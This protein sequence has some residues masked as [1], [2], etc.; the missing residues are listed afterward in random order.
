MYIYTTVA[1][2]KQIEINHDDGE[3]NYFLKMNESKTFS[4][5]KIDC[6]ANDEIVW[7]VSATSYKNGYNGT[8][9]GYDGDMSNPN[10]LGTGDSVTYTAPPL[11]EVHPGDQIA[12]RASLKSDPNVFDVIIIQILE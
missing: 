10:I 12:I 2:R 1:P 6:A 8:M 11:T 4:A 9:T 7:S 5:S 3:L